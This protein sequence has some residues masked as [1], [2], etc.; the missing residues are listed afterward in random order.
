MFA[1]PELLVTQETPDSIAGE[2]T[3]H[4]ESEHREEVRWDC[5]EANLPSDACIRLVSFIAEKNLLDIDRIPLSREE[6]YDSF[7]KQTE[8]TLQ[9]H[10]FEAALEELLSVK[11]ARLEN[12]QEF[13]D[14]FVHE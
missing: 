8:S 4:S 10:K 14:F 5:A 3:W 11:V 12:G 1:S 7:C 6:L 13:D 9:F 2:L